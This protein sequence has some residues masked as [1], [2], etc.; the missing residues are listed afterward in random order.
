[1]SNTPNC[2]PNNPPSSLI[3]MQG[4]DMMQV[5]LRVPMEMVERL[6]NIAKIFYGTRATALRFVIDHGL[7]SVEA[8]F[9]NMS[10]AKKD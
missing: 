5:S 3:G 1:M 2:T 9:S 10:V 8:K 4:S 6:D 7:D